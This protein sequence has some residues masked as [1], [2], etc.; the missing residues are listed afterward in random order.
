MPKKL[1][2]QYFTGRKKKWVKPRLV[3][4][5]RGDR[6]EMVL[7]TCKAPHWSGPG[8]DAGLCSDPGGSHCQASSTS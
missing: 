5:I 6:Q 2:R 4:L 8:G 7:V 3:V 1:A